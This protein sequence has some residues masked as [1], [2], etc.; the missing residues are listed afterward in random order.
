M[1]SNGMGQYMSLFF[2]CESDQSLLSHWAGVYKYLSRGWGLGQLSA[3]VNVPCNPTSAALSLCA[4]PSLRFAFRCSPRRR[5][6]AWLIKMTWLVHYYRGWVPTKNCWCE[7]PQEELASR[8]G[9]LMQNKALEYR[10]PDGVK[11]QRE[12]YVEPEVNCRKSLIGCLFV[13]KIT[14]IDTGHCLRWKLRI[15]IHLWV[16]KSNLRCYWY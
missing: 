3:A 6:L 1:L 9:K 2:F 16:F 15:V 14:Y 5:I 8:Q 7:E 11:G 13:V 12:L 4:V 10:K